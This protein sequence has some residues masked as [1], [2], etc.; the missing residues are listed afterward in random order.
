MTTYFHKDAYPMADL[1]DVRYSLW[2]AGRNHRAG[3]LDDFSYADL[4]A[5]LMDA[6]ARMELAEKYERINDRV[7]DAL[8]RRSAG[9][10]GSGNR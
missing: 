3:L 10:D 8:A 6:M 9:I 5:L 7:S 2:L 1:D 4:R